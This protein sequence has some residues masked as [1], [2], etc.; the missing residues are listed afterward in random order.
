MSKSDYRS[1]DAFSELN[2]AK[3]DLATTKEDALKLVAE[4]EARL[5]KAK[6]SVIALMDHNQTFKARHDGKI[7]E[8]VTHRNE[9]REIYV[10]DEPEIPRTW[11]LKFPEPEGVV[12]TPGEM[13]AI[14]SASPDDGF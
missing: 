2:Y 3:S 7:Y 5:A 12:A 10:T 13:V 4:A 9:A 6:S 14:Q 11:D 1:Y 8:V